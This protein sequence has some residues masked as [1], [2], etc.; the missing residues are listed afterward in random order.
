[1]ANGKSQVWVSVLAGIAVLFGIV[2]LVAGAWMFAPLIVIGLIALVV[3]RSRK[4]TP[5]V[6]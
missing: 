5:P 2:A 1:M 3:L 6:S 4:Q